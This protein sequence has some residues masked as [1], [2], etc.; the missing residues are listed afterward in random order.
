MCIF[1]VV[2]DGFIGYTK[3]VGLKGCFVCAGR[4]WLPFPALYVHMAIRA[5]AYM[6]MRWPV[7]LEALALESSCEGCIAVEFSTALRRVSASLKMDQ[8]VSMEP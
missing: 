7:G 4:R 2:F 6:E 8:S 1:G 5:Y 3:G